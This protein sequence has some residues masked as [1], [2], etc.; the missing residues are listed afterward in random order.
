MKRTEYEKPKYSM[1]WTYFINRVYAQN[2]GEDIFG[3]EK[4]GQ[5]RRPDNENIT[6]LALGLRDYMS[7]HTAN[8]RLYEGYDDDR[9]RQR[10]LQH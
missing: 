8:A 4:I 9:R 10:T 1:G 5:L 3:E 6:K 2:I 7:W